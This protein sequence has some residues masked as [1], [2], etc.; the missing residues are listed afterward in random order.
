MMWYQNL[1]YKNDA[2]A[3]SGNMRPPGAIQNSFE[4]A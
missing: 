1:S 3:N 2:S 4:E